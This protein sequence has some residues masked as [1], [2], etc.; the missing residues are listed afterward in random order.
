MGKRVFW[1]VV[2]VVAIGSLSQSIQVAKALADGIG[3]MLLVRGAVSLAALFASL[4][5]LTLRVYAIERARGNVVRPV[6]WFERILE[7]GETGAE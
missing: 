2:W 7:K 5:L 1:A 4:F 6:A 3:P